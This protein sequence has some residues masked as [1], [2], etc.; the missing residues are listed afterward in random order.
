M[1][2]PRAFLKNGKIAIL[3]GGFENLSRLVRLSVTVLHIPLSPV[4]VA[5][6]VAIRVANSLRSNC[7]LKAAAD[8]ETFVAPPVPRA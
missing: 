2:F 6:P 1:P 5:R 8:R 3:Q 7:G 4:I